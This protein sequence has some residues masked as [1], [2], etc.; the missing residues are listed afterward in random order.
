VDGLGQI[1]PWLSKDPGISMVDIGGGATGTRC[2][3]HK[4]RGQRLEDGET[5]L[6]LKGTVNVYATAG[7]GPRIA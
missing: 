6:L 4:T 1:S 3:Y 2:D 5:E 7:P